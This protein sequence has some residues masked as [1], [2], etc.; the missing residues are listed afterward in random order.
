[1]D[2][3][4][5]VNS[6]MFDA[7]IARLVRPDDV[8]ELRALG[9]PQGRNFITVVSGYYGDSG[10]L[11]RDA[12]KLD[13]AGA[14]G[15]YLTLNPCVRSLLARRANRCA[16]IREKDATTGDRDIL[17]RT[18]LLVDLDPVRPSGISSTDLEHQAALSRAARIAEWLTG[19]LGWPAPTTLD[20]GNGTQLLYAVDLPND[21]G[22]LQLVEGCLHALAARFGDELVAVDTTVGN[23]S[24]IIR[25][26][27]GL[28]RKGDDTLDRPH[29]RASI[30]SLPPV[31]ETVPRLGLERLT[32]HV[33]VN[34]EAVS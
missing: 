31:F 34:P 21:A 22:A 9:V 5:A 7:G 1:M 23:A 10:A 16:A 30:I 18:R 29:R 11:A 17:R 28:N 3:G 4:E 15:V 6:S 19:A 13:A 27:G 14:K 32:R 26:P 12:E 24:R 2:Q 33:P 20:S 8:H 25:L